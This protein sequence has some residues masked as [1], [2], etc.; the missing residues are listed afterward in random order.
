MPRI[1]RNQGVRSGRG[2][3]NLSMATPA[4]AVKTRGVRLKTVSLY[5]LVLAVACV[6]AFPSMRE[7]VTGKSGASRGIYRAA[8]HIKG[9]RRIP[10]VVNSKT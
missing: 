4:T 9:P 1:K 7:Q 10:W 2:Q 6:L 3:R 8:E 5:T